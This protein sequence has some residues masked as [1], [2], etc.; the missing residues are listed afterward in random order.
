MALPTITL[1]VAPEHHQLIR[2]IGAALRTRPELASVLRDVLQAQ[3]DGLTDRDTDV[4]QAF[5]ER[6]MLQSDLTHRT[7]A[8]AESINDRVQAVDDRVKALEQPEA[9]RNTDGDTNVLQ[10]ILE[11]IAALEEREPRMTMIEAL[12]ARIAALESAEDPAAPQ[13]PRVAP[14]DPKPPT[15]GKRRSPTKVTDELRRRAHDL[16]AAGWK[17]DAIAAELQVGGGTVSAI[18]AAPK[19]AG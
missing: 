4:L 9:M 2:D 17:R 11:R 6:L 14:R 12:R 19:P 18:L 15:A 5:Q 1:R 13:P 8:F 10:P 3:H 7:M 16:N